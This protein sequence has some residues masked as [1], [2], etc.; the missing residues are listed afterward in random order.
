MPRRMQKT[1]EIKAE[2]FKVAKAEGRNRK[3][4]RR[5]RN[6]KNEKKNLRKKE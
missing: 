1:V 6:E 5:K 3:E 4:M 2:K